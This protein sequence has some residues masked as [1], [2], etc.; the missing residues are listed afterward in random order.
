M[1]ADMASAITGKEKT[2][3]SIYLKGLFMDKIVLKEFTMYLK[4]GK[5]L[6]KILDLKLDYNTD[7]GEPHIYLGL[8]KIK[9]AYRCQGY[10][11]LVLRDIINFA[12]VHQINI[13][14]YATNVY[15]SDLERL[16]A[17]YIKHGF[18]LMNE[19]EGYFLYNN[20]QNTLKSM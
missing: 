16:Y 19:K 20:V 15:G 17:F 8:I 2:F 10:G 9:K 14:L 13:Q 6:G 12:N 1:K 7:H 5:Y 11:S 4:K 3:Q 18:I